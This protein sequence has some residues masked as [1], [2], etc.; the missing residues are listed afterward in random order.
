MALPQRQHLPCAVPYATALG[1]TLSFL[2]TPTMRSIDAV[3][4]TST[5]RAFV[6]YV[7]PALCAMR[8]AGNVPSLAHGPTLYRPCLRSPR[9]RLRRMYPKL[10]L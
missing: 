5:N 10:H 2:G 8:D 6:H 7:C 9:N 4:T 1:S 3:I